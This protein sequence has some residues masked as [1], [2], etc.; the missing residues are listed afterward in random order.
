MAQQPL[1]GYGLLIIKGTRSQSDTPHSVGL[2][3]TRD[4]ADEETSD[5]TE[6]HKRQ[7]SM[8]LEDSNP[9]SY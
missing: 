2:L 1:L 8:P 7:T 9:K 4:Q 6:T 5:N 3:C